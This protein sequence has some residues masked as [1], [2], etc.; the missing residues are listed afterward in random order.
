MREERTRIGIK[1]NDGN[2]NRGVCAGVRS[3]RKQHVQVA[4]MGRQ[5]EQ[6]DGTM[7]LLGRVA[8]VAS[9]ILAQEVLV[10]IVSFLQ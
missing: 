7:V 1:Y 2:D 10:R 8:L 6:K 9:A 5:A 3:Y 4:Q